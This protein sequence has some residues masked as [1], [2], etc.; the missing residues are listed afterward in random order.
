[1]LDQTTFPPGHDQRRFRT[2]SAGSEFIGHA[3]IIRFVRRH[4]WIII[5]SPLIMVAA[6][7]VYVLVTDPI[8]TARAQILIDPKMPQLLREQSG[9]VNFSL[10][11]A[12]VE[13]QMAVLRSEKIATMVINDLNLNED[14]DFLGRK[15]SPLGTLTSWWPSKSDR[16]MSELEQSRR[17]ITTF[18]AGLDVRRTG[19]SYAIDIAF[20]S[21]DPEKA[22]RIANATAEAYM[23]DQIET[24][25]ETARVGSEW[26]EQRLAQLRTQLNN[27]TQMVQE[28]RAKHDYR[29]RSRTD[30]G[31]DSGQQAMVGGAVL[32]RRDDYTLEELETT[33]ETYRKI[34]E[35]YLQGF[36]TSVQRQS[37]PVADTRVITPA[38]RPLAKSHPRTVLTL[39]LAGLAGIMIGVGIAVVRHSLDRSVRLSQQI[40]DE[41]GLECLGSLPRMVGAW[42]HFDEAAKTPFSRFSGS[43]KSVKTVI[44][45]VNKTRSIRCLGITSALPKEGKSTVASNL[46][47]LFSM[48]GMRTLVIDADMFNPTLTRNFAPDSTAGLI[49][50]VKDR[51]RA[52]TFIVPAG[53][54]SFDLL[55]AAGKIANSNDM[56]GSEQMQALL[57]DLF[58]SY[59]IVIVDVPPANPVVD[60]L[61]L[62]PLLDGVVVV[63]EWGHTS[64]DL[65]S[66]TLRSLRMA[67]AS[68]LGVVMNKV[69]DGSLNGRTKRGAHYY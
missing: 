64:L 14:P 43:L 49:D 50:A 69:D 32:E 41:L 60:G 63:A 57:Q 16:G 42:D 26:L 65:L 66:E 34:Y 9:E 18:E 4:L 29:I 36:T 62:S 5:G 33:A 21:K 10:D 25:S 58:Q 68:I 40:R 13:S 3:D 67:K 6:A 61:A 15:R 31:A 11:N 51:D 28:F 27:A 12:Q 45:L 1:M 59:D 38:T 22:A 35:S 47:T 7:F 44:G 30:K 39:A 20:S 46:A 56:L 52:R 19:L 54:A 48:S 8:F 37:F 53:R 23:R 2:L 17:T 55:P 24:K